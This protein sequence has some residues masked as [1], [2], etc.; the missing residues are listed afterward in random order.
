MRN[1]AL[2]NDGEIIVVVGLGSMGK[3][4]IRI[5]EQLG[6][7][8][9]I[10]GVDTD[11]TR[12][13]EAESIFCIR[14]ENSLKN[15][16]EIK[17]VK[18]V[19]VSS[20]PLTHFVII[21]EALMNRCHVFSEINVRECN[22]EYLVRLANQ[23]KCLLFLSSTMLYREEIKYIRRVVE[24]SEKKINY[25]YHV[26]QYL[27]DWHPWERYQEY[28]VAD[29]RTD[30]CREIMAIEMPWIID[31][32]GTIM[33]VKVFRNRISSLEISYPDCYNIIVLHDTGVQG[34]LQFDVVSRKAERSL[35]L[36]GENIFISWNGTPEGLFEYDYHENIE[37]KI[38]LYD[39]VDHLTKYNQTIIE[40]AYYDEVVN[41]FG[42]L[43]N[44]EVPK[45]SFEKDKI[46]LKLLDQIQ[47]EK[48]GWNE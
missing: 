45:Y 3:R 14:T 34:T 9:S 24:N 15:V 35:K 44:Y 21:E 19:F 29:P 23:K 27:P 30:A 2:L 8:N 31:C 6:L 4:R 36:I 5:L 12:R 16:Y 41:F 33:D 39:G 13:E 26:G 20:T 37:R 47:G 1:K 7:R 40:N 48:Y 10:I 17:R 38:R 43:N 46:V 28:F 32:F 11:E 22:Y 25:I 18:I 42:V